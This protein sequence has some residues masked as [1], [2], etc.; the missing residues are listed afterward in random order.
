MV[1]TRDNRRSVDGVQA[2]VEDITDSKQAQTALSESEERLRAVFETAQDCIF[3]KNRDLVYTHVN[4]AFL[5]AVDLSESDV[6]G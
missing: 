5:R 1:P 4:P 6:I 3:L 2:I